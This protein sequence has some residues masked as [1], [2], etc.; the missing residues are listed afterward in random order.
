M[1][2]RIRELAEQAGDSIPEFHFGDWN[3]PNEFVEKFAELIVRKCANFIKNT[4][5]DP[6]IG[7]E[8]A[9]ALLDHFGVK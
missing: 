9:Q 1:N 7:E 3:I 4:D 2:D 6:D 8:D 5:P